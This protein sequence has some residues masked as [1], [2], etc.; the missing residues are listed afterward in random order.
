[1]TIMP[2]TCYKNYG[3]TV[4]WCASYDVILKQFVK[5]RL[6]AIELVLCMHALRLL[7]ILD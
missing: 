6:Q 2:K 5:F 4:I 1:M 3:H 7:E